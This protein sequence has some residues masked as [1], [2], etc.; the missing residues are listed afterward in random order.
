MGG[1]LQLFGGKGQRFPGNGPLPHFD[2]RPWNCH[3][4]G[5]CVM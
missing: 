2:G 5:G 3:G 4:T 1:L